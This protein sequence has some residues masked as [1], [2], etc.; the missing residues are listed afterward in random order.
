M[1]KL[2]RKLSGKTNCNAC[3]RTVIAYINAHGKEHLF[4]G[5]VNGRITEEAVGNEGFGYDP[6]FI[7]D[8]YDITYAQMSLGEKNRIR[9]R[10]KVFRK[11][12]EAI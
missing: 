8:G 9:H 12:A 10:A 11:F 2:L 7:P 3:F 1:N 5:T 4:E 6:V